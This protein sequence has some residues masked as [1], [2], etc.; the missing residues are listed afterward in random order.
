MI[1]PA[2]SL[3]PSHPIAELGWPHAAGKLVD[4]P[5]PVAL[6]LLGLVGH[7]L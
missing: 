6:L 2:Q 7:E 1:G 4:L 5:P 3:L